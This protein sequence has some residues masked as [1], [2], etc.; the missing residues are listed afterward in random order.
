VKKVRI[1]AAFGAL[2]DW[3]SLEDGYPLNYT[4]LEI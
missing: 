3:T 4:I 2:K 1:S